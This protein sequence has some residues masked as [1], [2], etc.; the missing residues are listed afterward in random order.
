MLKS[1]A[2]S[3]AALSLVATPSVAFEVKKQR[4][5]EQQYRE[6]AEAHAEKQKAIYGDACALDL[7][8]ADGKAL[9]GFQKDPTSIFNNNASGMSVVVKASQ[10]INASSR[11]AGM[12][13]DAAPSANRSQR[14]AVGV[15]IA[16]STDRCHPLEG[17]EDTIMSSIITAALPE[18]LMGYASYQAGVPTAVIVGTNQPVVSAGLN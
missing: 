10:L 3:V 8:R 2:I 13:L 12:L 7:Q 6:Y 11:S 5:W 16:A 4:L 14:I 18:V 15:A 9:M 17:S 1:L